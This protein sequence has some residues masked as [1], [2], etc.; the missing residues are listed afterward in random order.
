MSI[1]TAPRVNDSPRCHQSLSN[2][3]PQL[4]SLSPE[5]QRVKLLNLILKHRQTERD[6]MTDDTEPRLNKTEL[7]TTVNTI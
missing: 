5:V 6:V 4:V 7:R 2:S 1:R 3:P